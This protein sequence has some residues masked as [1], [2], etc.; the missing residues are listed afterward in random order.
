[1]TVTDYYKRTCLYCSVVVMIVT[2]I[3]AIIENYDYKS[4]WITAE[5]VIF[6]LIAYSF[7]YCLIM[8]ILSATL[9]LN[10]FETIKQRSIFSFLSWF[11]L[12]F[13]FSISILIHE[14]NYRIEYNKGFDN[15]FMYLLLMT[16][17]F[18]FGLT[19]SYVKYRKTRSS[20]HKSEIEHPKFE[21]P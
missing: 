20:V 8:S 2:T 1:M 6:T 21:I 9:L 7:I 11:L 14:I 18:I 19:R 15:S 4:E 17:P 5:L 13:G 16:I 10:N 3:F 12:P